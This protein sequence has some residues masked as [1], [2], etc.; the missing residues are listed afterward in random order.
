MSFRTLNKRSFL[1]SIRNGRAPAL[2]H[3][4]DVAVWMRNNV[5]FPYN[6]DLSTRVPYILDEVS[7]ITML[8]L[9]TQ[10]RIYAD[11]S[12]GI[13]R[14][15]DHCILHDGYVASQYQNWPL[16]GAYLAVP[17]EQGHYTIS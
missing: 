1:P 3:T 4:L 8:W 11:G 6:V 2:R 17:N 7:G 10:L 5:E 12:F 13:T 15:S 16:N 9:N 14:R